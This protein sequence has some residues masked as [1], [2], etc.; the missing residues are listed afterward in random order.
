[1]LL[2]SFAVNHSAMSLGVNA[3]HETPDDAFCVSPRFTNVMK[4]PSQKCEI[5]IDGQHSCSAKLFEA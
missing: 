4:L 3:S 5:F 1:M 2:T